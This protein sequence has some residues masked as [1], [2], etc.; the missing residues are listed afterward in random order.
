MSNFFIWVTQVRTG[1]ILTTHSK[2][3][4]EGCGLNRNIDWIEKLNT[5]NETEWQTLK[6][7][8]K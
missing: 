6:I 8:N 1:M 5:R 7:G 4:T 2:T 3:P